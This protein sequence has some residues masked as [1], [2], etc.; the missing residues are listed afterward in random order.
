MGGKRWGSEPGAK[1]H[2][3]GAR[4]GVPSQN[5]VIQCM[6]QLSTGLE[7]DGVICLPLPHWP[8]QMEGHL[9]PGVVSA[10]LCWYR[11]GQMSLPSC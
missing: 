8:G 5:Q 7:A 2:C 4:D 10:I 11:A 6:T 9:S 1:V 3:C